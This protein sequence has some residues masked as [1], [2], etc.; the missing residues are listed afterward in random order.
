LL[1]GFGAGAFVVLWKIHDRLEGISRQLEAIAR[2]AFP[3]RF[4]DD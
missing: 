3:E 4:R 2:I 1:I